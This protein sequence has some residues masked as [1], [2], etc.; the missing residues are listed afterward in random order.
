MVPLKVVPPSRLYWNCAAPSSPAVTIL[1]TIFVYAAAG[2]PES[3]TEPVPAATP[4]VPVP[5][6]T[7]M[8]RPCSEPSSEARHW[9]TVWATSSCE[10]VS[11]T[12]HPVLRIER[13]TAVTASTKLNWPSCLLVPVR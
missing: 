11:A 7:T 4:P 8:P 9:S 10:S 3:V 1:T 2:V 13:L 12:N 5:P 6:A